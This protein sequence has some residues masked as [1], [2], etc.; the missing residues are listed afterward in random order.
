MKRINIAS[1]PF[2]CWLLS[3]SS[4]STTQAKSCRARKAISRAARN[5]S[6]WPTS[7]R[8]PAL[9]FLQVAMLLRRPPKI[10]KNGSPRTLFSRDSRDNKRGRHFCFSFFFFVCSLVWEGALHSGRL[11]LF[12]HIYR[13]YGPITFLASPTP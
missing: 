1:T 8:R 7:R 6:A 10:R 12:F 5:E 11:A 2:P 13:Y 4:T 9:R 3:S